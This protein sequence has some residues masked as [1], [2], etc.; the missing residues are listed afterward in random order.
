MIPGLGLILGLRQSSDS[1]AAVLV[2]N[3]HHRIFKRQQRALYASK[4]QLR[5][6]SER[7]A[8]LKEHL[9]G[10][11]S[12]PYRCHQPPHS[13]VGLRRQLPPPAA[14]PRAP[15]VPAP[16]HNTRARNRDVRATFTA[17]SGHPTL[18]PGSG[19]FGACRGH[20]GPGTYLESAHALG[21]KISKHEH[22]STG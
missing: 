7:S 17:R 2:T 11:C 16:G 14:A 5:G 1:N 22:V 6:C 15:S 21:L 18:Q 20:L 4:V 9:L 10:R 12:C 3:L 19:R 8:L 13:Q